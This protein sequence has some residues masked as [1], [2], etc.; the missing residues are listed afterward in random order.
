[1]L[2]R[3]LGSERRSVLLQ[4]A[5]FVVAGSSFCCC[6]GLVT[7]NPGTEEAKGLTAVMGEAPSL[8]GDGLLFFEVLRP[9]N[10]TQEHRNSSKSTRILSQHH[11][12]LS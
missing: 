10:L 1:M 3:S 6:R 2:L 9:S 12:N 8:A 5:C 4:G 11:K 7:R